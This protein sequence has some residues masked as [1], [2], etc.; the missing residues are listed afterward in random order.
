MTEDVLD[1]GSLTFTLQSRVLREL[2]ER[3]V[4]Q[5]EVALLELIKNAY[6]ADASVCT[7]TVKGRML[8]IEDDG[9]GM[10]LRRFTT[11]WMTIG[12]GLKASTPTSGRYG[13][14]VTGEKGIGRFAVRFLGGR[15][16]LVSTAYDERRRCLTELSTVFDWERFDRE[17]DI[18]NIQVKY[19]LR[20]PPSDT[21]TGTTLTITHPRSSFAAIKWKQVRTGAAGVITG[22][23]GRPVDAPSADGDDGRRRDPGFRLKISTDEGDEED[24][25]TSLLSFYV[26]RASVDLVGDRARIDVFRRSSE[27]PY[28]VLEADFPNVVG[29]VRADVR[30]FPRRAGALAG[31]PIDGRIAYTWLREN[32]GVS[33]FDNGFQVRPYGFRGDDWLGVDADAGR[34]HR[35]PRSSLTSQRFRMTREQRAAPGE[36]W[37]LRLPGSAQLVGSVHVSGRRGPSAAS[38]KG[39]VAAAD[40]E[41][42]VDNE[43]FRQLRDL[44]RGAV[45]T[46]AYADR[47]LQQDEAA[48]KA[49]LLVEQSRAKTT[50]A[51]REVEADA[52]LA[53]AQRDKVVAMLVESQERVERHEEGTK[54]RERQLEVLSLLGVVG[55]F[56]THEF[57]AAVEVLRKATSDLVALAARE[58]TFGPA[59]AALA[60]HGDAL[61]SFVEYSRAYVQGARTRPATAYAARPR[62]V[63]I[64][65]VFGK[66]AVDRG[67]AV[68]VEVEPTVMVPTIP[69]ALYN[70]VAQNLFTNALKAV[71][72]KRSGPD[73]DRRIVFRAWNDARYH[74]LQV[75]D[76]GV[77]IAPALRD[78]VFDPL[79]TTTEGTEDPLG[80]GM[81]LGLA[82]VR[83]GAR[84]FGG[85]ASLVA[86]PPGFE[87]CV[88]A[89]FPL[90]QESTS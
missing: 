12:T 30:F 2:G 44:I 36:N 85:D 68:D 4:K 63:Q 88:E 79:F 43:A 67:I 53:P 61:R 49:R 41:G 16:R 10:T 34:N 25:A 6:D 37:M 24:L 8:T 70:G 77:G 39:L 5:P 22:P 64:K 89:R 69:A 57:G 20:K 18:G 31:A 66:Y 78:F 74:R 33:V 7:V 27:K 19:V 45:E 3:L 73:Q 46:I 15:L 51:I 52:N 38:R 50:A 32:G 47:R 11:A 82:L 21:G 56:M 28:V 65:R 87:T 76:T 48:E 60:R 35:D 13:R 40:R 71:V 1:R 14:P 84:A 72:A 55:G 62:L 83:R 26:L 17:H 80:S 42:F 23:H 86:A 81:G 58:P 59:A 54:E 75:S 9:G 90:D 29:P